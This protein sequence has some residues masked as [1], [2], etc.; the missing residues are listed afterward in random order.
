M[1]D[2]IYRGSRAIS[3]PNGYCGRVD[4][5]IALLGG[6]SAAP[7]MAVHEFQIETDPATFCGVFEPVSHG[8]ETPFSKQ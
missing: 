6:R 4:T 7:A 1:A 3:A 8:F 2:R 5:H